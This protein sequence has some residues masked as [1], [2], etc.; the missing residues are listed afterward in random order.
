MAEVA[1]IA[2]PYARA[3]FEYAQ[4]AKALARWGDLLDTAAAVAARTS[5]RRDAPPSMGHAPNF[6]KATIDGSTFT[7]PAARRSTIG[8][9]IAKSAK[10]GA[11]LPC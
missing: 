2:R 4:D 8:V 11:L 7:P 6:S 1:T 9:G 5:R 10:L 3:A